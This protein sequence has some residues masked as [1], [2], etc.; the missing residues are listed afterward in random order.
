[1]GVVYRA[2]D[3]LNGETVALKR[4]TIGAAD[5]PTVGPGE[6]YAPGAPADRAVTAADSTDHDAQSL[7]LALAHEFRML[8]GLRHPHIISVL[9]YG[10]DRERRPFFTMELLEGAQT[11]IDAGADLP[12]PQRV[13]LLIQA[14][15]A[16]AYLHRRGV[17]HHDLKPANILVADGRLR[18]LDFGLAVVSS[19]QRADDSFGTMLY[20]APEVLDG[21]PY[22]E[23]ADLYSLGVLAYELLVGRHP[24][25]TESTSDFFDHVFNAA[26]DLTPLAGRPALAQVVGRLLAKSPQGR[27]ASAQA[28]IDDLRA[29]IGLAAPLDA[30]AIRESYLQAA[31]FVGREDE[32]ARLAAALDQA[33]LLRGSSWLIGG[34]SGVGKSR[35]LDELRTRALVSGCLVLRGQAEENGSLPYQLWREPL[36]RLVL[37]L[38]L[39]DLEAGVL[40]ELIP[41]LGALLGRPVIPAPELPGAAGQQRLALTVVDLFRRLPQPIALILEDLQWSSESLL[42]LKQLN[43][44]VADLPLLILASYRNDERPDLPEQLPGMHVLPLQ[45]L[46]TDEIAILSRSMLGTGGGRDS[47]V[48]LLQRET[49]GNVFFL[50]EV[51]RALAEESGSLD[52][53][54]LM[55]LPAHV[56]A[57]GVEQVIQRRL[58]QVPAWGQPLLPL[59]AVIGRQ[60]DLL[61]LAQLTAADQRLL[62]AQSLEQWLIACADAAVLTVAGRSWQFAHDKLR[63]AL[64]RAHPGPAH[65]RAVALAMEQVYVAPGDY[66]TDPA[67]TEVLYEHWRAAGDLERTL[68]YLEPLCADL[69]EI[70]AEYARA[71]RLIEES[72]AQLNP[73]H[74]RRAPLLNWLSQAALHQGDSATAQAHAELALTLAELP[75]AR[76]VSL[77]NLGRA[78]DYQGEYGTARS[79]YQQSL[80]IHQERGDQPGIAR[81]LHRLGL[82]AYYQGEYDAARSYYQQSLTIHQQIGD[83]Q[84]IA[85]SLNGLGLVADGLRDYATARAHYTRQLQISEEIGDRRNIAISLNNLGFVAHLQGDYRAAAGY[86]QQCVAISR[87][88]GERWGVA[89]SLNNLGF[90]YLETAQPDMARHTWRESLTISRDLEFYPLILESAIGVARL[91]QHAGQRYASAALAGLVAAHPATLAET[92][93]LYLAPLLQVLKDTLGDDNLTAALA[94]GAALDLDTVARQLI[95]ELTNA[96]DAAGHAAP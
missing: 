33:R 55:T 50:V 84:G 72:L 96:G 22:T 93:D 17:V 65:H 64:L 26:P 76:A 30:A 37:E 10:F 48:Q 91:R 15:E 62:P 82:V 52:Q 19:Q 27:P 24:F 38:P 83:R 18:L 87:Q 41:D 71:A 20:L 59:A 73:A 79:Y 28:T 2:H 32:Q 56:F 36:R 21:E 31:D 70:R 45:R 77:Y 47:V 66:P 85:M 34:E 74:P 86:Y 25:P 94:E 3:R 60:I 46:S 44:F 14:L 89:T 6:P 54:G 53:I 11:V 58:A 29:A 68:H 1:M 5:L 40:R 90:V 81:S 95:E 69:I 43:R 12:P 78:A 4:V 16:L 35:L 75:Q 39:S 92:R 67:Y 57:G 61:V 88:I 51:V 7:R 42:I 49:E 13:A 63:T 80:A 9:D 8:A 23:A